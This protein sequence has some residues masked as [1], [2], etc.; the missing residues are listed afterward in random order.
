MVA[1]WGLV[2]VVFPGTQQEYV[3][4][5][6]AGDAVALPVG[7]VSW[8]YNPGSNHLSVLSLGDTSKTHRPGEF[9]VRSL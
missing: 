3:R 8:W 6:Q 2:G 4:K 9:T 1:G 7:T 5:I